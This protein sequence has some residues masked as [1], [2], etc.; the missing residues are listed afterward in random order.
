MK[1]QVLAKTKKVKKYSPLKEYLKSLGKNRIILSFEE[2]ETILKDN[3]PNS[4]R[5]YKAF[6]GNNRNNGKAYDHSN[7]WLE[8]GLEIEKKDLENGLITFQKR[9]MRPA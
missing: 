3:L 7:S 2:I 5:K 6:W 9:K 1:T 4:A 8:A